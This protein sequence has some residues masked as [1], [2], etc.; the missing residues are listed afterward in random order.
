MITIYKIKLLTIVL[1]SSLLIAEKSSLDIQND[2]NKKNTEL[3]ELTNEIIKVEKLINNKSKEE[4]LSNDLIEQINNK[5]SLTEK[6]IKTLNDEENYLIKL[7]Y[8]AKEQIDMKEKEQFKLQ[9]QLKN[10]VRYL[11]KYGKENLISQLIQSEDWNKIIYRTK[12]LEILN[13]YDEIIKKRI[14]KNIKEL[15]SEKTIL[16]I[17]KNSKK[18]LIQNK[19]IEFKNLEN[20]KSRKKIYLK[21][22][23]DQ[24]DELR[25]NLEL[26]KN[27]IAKVG[28]II[29]K[30][31][32][33]KNKAQ[34][35]EEEIAKRRQEKNK[36]TSGNFAKMKGKLDWPTNGK[37]VG[38][39]GKTTNANTN[40][41][42]EN[43]GIDILTSKNEKV[44]S[45]LD[46]IVLAITYIT[47]FGDLIIV[48]H[49]SGYFTVYS[50]LKDIKVYEN[51][52]IDANT[53]LA[54]VAKGSNFDYPNQAVFNF[55]V[56]SN[57]KKVD[58]EIWLKK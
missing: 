55:Q 1:F 2:I 48:D 19:N 22:I 41:V 36:P 56:W 9:N 13:E 44:Y 6:L 11:Y 21:K 53:Y 27:M 47:N 15:K 35:R 10:R 16:Q 4:Q 51:Q 50:N 20:E 37:I 23:Q 58:P 26:K 18:K 43:I 7:I 34:K 14:H 40:I 32:S 28:N 3:E 31:Y 8:K 12:Y 52:Y 33:D 5:I 54:Q 39:F 38:K 45:V 30:L 24:K 25:G 49:G 42:T 29:Q 17:K 57:E 46:G